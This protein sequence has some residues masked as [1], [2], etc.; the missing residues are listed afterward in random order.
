MR[1][2]VSVYVCVD[3]C[4]R[5]Q[6]KQQSVIVKASE[7]DCFSIWPNKINCTVYLW[8]QIVFQYVFKVNVPGFVF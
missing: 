2:L 5:Y 6:W 7:H 3:D 4:V 1:V 8:A